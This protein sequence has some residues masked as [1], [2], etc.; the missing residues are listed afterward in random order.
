MTFYRDLYTTRP[1]ISSWPT[2]INFWFVVPAKPE[3][4]PFSLGNG[5]L[6]DGDTVQAVCTVQKGDLPII[7]EWFFNKA[8]NK[9]LTTD[10]NIAVSKVGNR[11]SLLSISSVGRSNAG[12]YTC[13]ATND[14]GATSYAATLD[15]NGTRTMKISEIFFVLYFSQYSLS[16]YLFGFSLVYI[17]IFFCFK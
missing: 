1:S 8:N 9:S 16:S 17:I 15:V 2:D 10:D 12:T 5:L 11:A 4:S 13:V 7:I 6:N 3:I 14:A